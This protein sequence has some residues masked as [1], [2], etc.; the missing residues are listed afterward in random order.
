MN[1]HDL[2]RVNRAPNHTHAP[3]RITLS[4]VSNVSSAL[5]PGAYVLISNESCFFN[6]GATNSTTANTSS[7]YLPRDTG[8]RLVVDD[9]ANQYV[10]GIVSSGTGVLSIERED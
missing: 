3:I 2:E 8:R 1:I 4:N 6:V 10:A 9:T 5:S 7:R